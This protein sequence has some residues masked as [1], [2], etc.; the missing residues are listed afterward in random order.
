MTGPRYD[1][2]VVGGVGVDTV[3]RV[4]RLPVEARDSVLVP[5]VR[6]Y[7]GHTGN[8]VAL[9]CQALGLATA[10][11]DV[12][13]DDPFGRLV[14]DRYADSGV[15]FRYT[16]HPSGTRRA[17][18]LVDDS[19]R[20]MSFY[21]GRHPAG[22]RLDPELY[23]PLLATTRHLHLSIM[24]FAR[25]LYPAAAELGLTVSTDLHD[26]DGANPYHLDFARQSDLVF[27]STAAL[28][29]RVEQTMRDLLREGRASVVVATA[30]SA[31]SLLLVRGENQVH[32]VPVAGLGLPVVDSNGAGDSYLA[33]F[34]AGYL[35]GRD[36]TE[37]ARWGAV[38]GEYSCQRPGTHTSFVDA[39]TLA[40]LL[41]PQVS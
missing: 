35:A 11:V 32:Q 6:E 20:R 39:A 24:D 21:D 33:A 5:P 26:W 41:G 29:D 25:H 9:G 28:G 10:L 17:V 2:L 13:G 19:G 7:V 1:V 16:T 8:G 38:A 30:G 36:W 3:V 23:Q 37:C 15:D 31:G 18:N 12:I 14:R 34:L 40:G 22:L 4:E 27:L